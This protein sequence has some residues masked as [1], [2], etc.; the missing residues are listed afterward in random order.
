MKII[1][2]GAHSEHEIV[3]TSIDQDRGHYVAW[4]SSDIAKYAISHYS[5]AE[6]IGILIMRYAL[7]VT[8][9]DFKE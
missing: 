7:K 6:A 5:E 3:V 1:K 9:Q 2:M 4:Y 8:E